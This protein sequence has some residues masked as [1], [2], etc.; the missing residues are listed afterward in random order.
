MLALGVLLF[1]INVVRALV[2]G[3]RAGDNPWGAGGLEWATTSPPQPY[4]F[5][6]L[7]LVESRYPLW[8]TP[9]Q[10]D[11]YIFKENLT[12][13]EVLVTTALDAQARAA[14]SF[15][16]AIRSCR[17]TSQSA[18]TFLL[19]SAM[20][21]LVPVIIW[22]AVVLGLLAVWH[23]P[24]HHEK[25]MA[26]VKAGPEGAEEVSTVVQ[27][28]GKKPPFYYGTLLFIAIE[29][30]E[31]LALIASYFY[32]RSSSNDWPPG[33][34]PRPELLLPII[35]TLLL[36]A[37]AVPTYLGDHAIKKGDQKGLIRNMILTVILETGFLVFIGLHLRSLNWNWDK[38]A[39]TSAYWV[40][41]VMHLLF[42]LIMIFENLYMLVHARQGFY[43][44]E[45]HWGVEV[46]G[47]SSY[48]IVAAWV[49][50]FFTVFLSPYLIK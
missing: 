49:A 9:Q 36:L 12:R 42:A 23:W 18:T 7:P 47:L 21:N 30:T 11:D 45:R 48:F 17:S 2:R 19:I 41:I 5:A 43:N 39:Y 31:F 16:P 38:N 32:L 40:L 14:Q 4:N 44:E 26:W 22:T 10:V 35:G 37:S 34:V 50:I 15:C 1:V 27:G 46:D 8:D 13:R 28:P 33:D 24:K 29:S 6:T 3:E 20:F 25:S